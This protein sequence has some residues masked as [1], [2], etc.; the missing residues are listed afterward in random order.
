MKPDS[1]V[2]CQHCHAKVGHARLR[3]MALTV[4][5]PIYQTH[6]PV[7]DGLISSRQEDSDQWQID[8]S[9]CVDKEKHV[10]PWGVVANANK[11]TKLDFGFFATGIEEFSDG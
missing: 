11:E 8:T 7:C 2:E 10:D 5:P 9:N 4:I 1:Y 3:H 6:C